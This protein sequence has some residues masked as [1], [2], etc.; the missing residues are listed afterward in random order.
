MVGTIMIILLFA[1]LG[2]TLSNGN[3]SF[4]IAGFN[5]KSREDKEKYDTVAL[6]KFMGKVMFVL[7]FSMVLWVVSEMSEIKWLFT[8]GLVLFFAIIISM[9][10]Y[11]NT[12]NRFKK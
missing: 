11:V 9:L 8:V 10:I 7:S 2:I 3:G 4:L 12:G 5:T 1:V 6:C